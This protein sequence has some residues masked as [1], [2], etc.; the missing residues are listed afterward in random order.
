[1]EAVPHAP[2]AEIRLVEV[3]IEVREHAVELR[4]SL[5]DGGLEVVGDSEH[6]LELLP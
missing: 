6:G 4:L 1:M 5:N 3:A 2:V